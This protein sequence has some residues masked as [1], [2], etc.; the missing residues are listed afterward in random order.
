MQL[1]QPKTDKWKD[2]Q[3][4]VVESD[5]EW[6]AT[7]NREAVK[8]EPAWNG[9]GQKVGTQIWCIDKSKVT[10]WPN[11]LCCLQVP[12]H[13]EVLSNPMDATISEHCESHNKCTMHMQ[14]CFCLGRQVSVTTAAT[15]MTSVVFRV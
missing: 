4:A 9:A 15:R 5:L 7:P 2:D 1:R 11:W 13:K 14:E 3:M 6:T 12:A 8:S 10:N